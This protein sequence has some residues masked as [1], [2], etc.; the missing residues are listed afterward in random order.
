MSEYKALSAPEQI[1]LQEEVERL[2]KE[3]AEYKKFISTTLRR[4][5]ELQLRHNDERNKHCQNR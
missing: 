1:A 4:G 3:N 5:F 2:R